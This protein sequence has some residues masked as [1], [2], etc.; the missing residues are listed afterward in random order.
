MKVVY[1]SRGGN[2]SAF[3]KKLG[4][5]DLV[6]IETGDEKVEGEYILITYT[7]GK[8]DMPKVVAK[9]LEA[10]AAGMK[11]VAASGNKDHFAAT[12]AGAAD[13]IAEQYGVPVIAKFDSEGMAPDVETVKAAL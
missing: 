1:A 12:F 11:G 6:K 3:V 9:F 4:A 2:V 8:G 5:D 13:K 10:N 7:D